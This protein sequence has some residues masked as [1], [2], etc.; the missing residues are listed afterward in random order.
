MTAAVLLKSSS[1][2]S[3]GAGSSAGGG[4]A[5]ELSFAASTPT[6]F[7]QH[8]AGSD[9]D[10]TLQDGGSTDTRLSPLQ[11]QTVLSTPADTTPH[12]HHQQDMQQQ[13][14]H[15][16]AVEEQ[17]QQRQHTTLTSLTTPASGW[18]TPGLQG[19]GSTLPFA[20]HSYLP[21]SAPPHHATCRVSRS[22]STAKGISVAQQSFLADTP[23]H[24]QPRNHQLQTP[25]LARQPSPNFA[26]PVGRSR[27][28]SSSSSSSSGGDDDN[29]GSGGAEQGRHGNLQLSRPWHMQHQ[30]PMR[31]LRTIASLPPARQ[32]HAEQSLVVERHA[33]RKCVSS[34]S[35]PT[36]QHAGGSSCASLLKKA[37]SL[38]QQLE[39]SWQ[40]GLAAVA[41]QAAAVKA[42]DFNPT[43]ARLVTRR[44][45]PRRSSLATP[46]DGV[47][48]DDEEVAQPQPQLTHMGSRSW[49]AV[50]AESGGGRGG[51]GVVSRQVSASAK[52][53]SVAA[54]QPGRSFSSA[55]ELL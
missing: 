11:D 53:G 54:C 46:G 35:S 48:S 34:V 50:L 18:S 14:Q 24:M 31:Q 23:R 15:D 1:L 10:T 49:R 32:Q 6:A 20:A 55:L 3:L 4:M 17:P 21:A 2:A 45:S 26:A 44:G 40:H 7:S 47:S 29:D 30:Q 12:N 38:R 9:V 33:L 52:T 25:L 43:H 27:R 5:A 51:T 39:A 42:Q 36:Q 41:G 28:H 37:P 16:P 19:T 22:S 13:Q 8:K